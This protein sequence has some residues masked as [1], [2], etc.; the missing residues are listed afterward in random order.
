MSSDLRC[1]A[2]FRLQADESG[3]ARPWA[4]A[5]FLAASPTTWS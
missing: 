3:S 4:S 1:P 2:R 5:I